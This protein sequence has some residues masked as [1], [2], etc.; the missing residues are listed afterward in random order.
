MKAGIVGLI[1][2]ILIAIAGA[3]YFTFRKPAGDITESPN[4]VEMNSQEASDKLEITGTQS[5]DSNLAIGSDSSNVSERY[6]EYGSLGLG[7][8]HDAS[9]KIVYFFYADWCPT[10][11]PVD[12]E[13][14]ANLNKIPEDVVIIKA[15]YNDQYTDDSEKALARDHSVTY[16]HTFVQID[17]TGKIISKW[18]GGGLDKLISSIK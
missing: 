3:A 17:Q 14:K 2:V 4:F 11:R 18:N 15:N 13:I 16:Q 8:P 7:S 6:L 5:I 12:A 9:K 1:I 10:C